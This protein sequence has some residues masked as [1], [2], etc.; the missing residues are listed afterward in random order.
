MNILVVCHSGLYRHPED[1]FVHALAAQYAALGHRVRAVVPAAWGK[2][3][4]DR[5][6]LAARRRTLEGVELCPLRYLSLSRYGA[7]GWNDA[8]VRLAAAPA[9][10][11]DGFAPQVIH[12]HTLGLDSRL[13]AWYRARTGAP[14]AVTAHGSDVTVPA[15]RGRWGQLARLCGEAD[16]VAAV[17]APLA[18]TLARCGTRTPIRV[19]HGGYRPERLRP[20]LP[21]DPLSILQ[22]GTLQD[23]KRA[24]VTLR[25]FA[26]LRRR[27][28]GL[29]LT[30]VGDGPR[31]G[32]LEALSRRLGTADG[33]RFTGRVPN[34]RVLELMAE[35][36]FFVLPS[37]GEGFGL[38]YLE[39]MAS[40]C[41]TLGTRGEGIQD[42]L[43]HG[44]NGLL[45]PPDRPEDLA[46][47]LD[48]CLREPE[49]ADALARRGRRDA[50][51]L[52]WR[53]CAQAYLTLFEE[54]CRA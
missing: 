41:V 16:H 2:E 20:G 28:P 12:A 6:R 40:G 22:V 10:G 30:L 52:T 19:I 24:D 45:V 34:A 46:R 26:L 8:A 5:G 47:A 3:L 29:H 27:W 9:R 50:A 13:G 11:L 23:Q 36:R 7:W 54:L 1:S 4:W 32:E 18:R 43:R 33:V 48:W 37:V 31:R 51:P 39:A 21:R 42:L 14:L 35:H 44:E 53:R 49:R 15:A 25:A 17:S 38:V